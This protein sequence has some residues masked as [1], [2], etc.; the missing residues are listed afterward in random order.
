MKVKVTGNYDDR[1]KIAIHRLLRAFKR[2]AQLVNENPDIDIN[3]IIEDNLN[4]VTV[5]V[6]SN[7]EHITLEEA[8]KEDNDRKYLILKALY[9]LLSKI[10][11]K[12][13][14]YGVLTGIRPTKLVHMYKTKLTDDEIRKI[15]INKY[16]VKEAKANLLLEVV[17]NQ[18]RNIGNINR[19]KD[20]VSIYINIPFCP[21]RCVYCSF[22]SY[23]NNY[24]RVSQEAYL[25]ALLAEIETVGNYLRE[26]KISI[27]TIYVGGG[28]PT[29][30]S[31]TNLERLLIGIKK[32]LL[33]N[34]VREYTIECGRPDTI[35]E[36][37]LQLLK[38]YNVSRIS[39]NP[40]TFNDETLRSMNRTHSTCDIIN[41]YRLAREKGLENINMDLIIGLPGEK[42]E[43]YIDS[44]NKVLTLDP[45]N[46]T[47]HYLAEKRNSDLHNQKI[48]Y[49][50]H[51]YQH[52]FDYAYQ[53]L[54]EHRY[55]PYYLYRQ[56][57]ITGN[58]ENVG[59]C[60]VGNECLYNILMI[61]EAQTIIGLGC[62][63]STK[64][65]DYHLI[66]N[67]KDLIS[68]MNSYKGYL[69]KKLEYLEELRNRN[70]G[71][72]YNEHEYE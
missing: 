4:L 65:N 67:P 21:S 66:L 62:N 63:A 61:E 72:I 64:F 6:W 15:L 37:K 9:K 35:N 38:Q 10:F 56:K 16:M 30:L 13:L 31:E 43:T 33:D 44:L 47:I 25:D 19:F 5:N 48:D 45:E 40:Q 26:K 29:A 18:Y 50:N 60:K 55:I 14:A 34:H 27:T 32:Y 54:K 1:L 8:V 42:F 7:E 11:M 46:I 58:L 71:S 23:P 52:F 24:Q 17:N 49:E 12:E 51:E 36:L 39:I 70:G 28:T 22:T 68:Y 53:T 3:I 2:N 57:H 59:Y 20:E 69:D 41:T